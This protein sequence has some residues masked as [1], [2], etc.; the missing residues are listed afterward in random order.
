MARDVVAVRLHWAHLCV[1]ET[2]C[3]MLPPPPVRRPGADLI[4]S[5]SALVV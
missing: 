3:P 5:L 4:R 2:S 1:L